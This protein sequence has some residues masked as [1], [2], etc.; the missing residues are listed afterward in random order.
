MYLRKFIWEPQEQ[1]VYVL[2]NYVLPFAVISNKQ[3]QSVSYAL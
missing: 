1:K 3:P 2:F